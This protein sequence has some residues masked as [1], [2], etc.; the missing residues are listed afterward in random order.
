LQQSR[1]Y[2]WEIVEE[3]RRNGNLQQELEDTAWKLAQEQVA[4]DQLEDQVVELRD[5]L[6][7]LEGVASSQEGDP[8]A[9]P[10]PDQ[11]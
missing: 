6:Q 7:Q 11:E 5:Q 8:E 9:P 2:A 3:Q 10:V 4:A 1:D